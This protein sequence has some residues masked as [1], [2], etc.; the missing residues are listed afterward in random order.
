MV[1]ERCPFTNEP[2]KVLFLSHSKNPASKL[3]MRLHPPVRLLRVMWKASE[4]TWRKD[5]P[6]LLPLSPGDLALGLGHWGP[7]IEKDAGCV[8]RYRPQQHTTRSAVSSRS[9]RWSFWLLTVT[10]RWRLWFWA[11]SGITGTGALFQ[12]QAASKVSGRGLS[13]RDVPPEQPGSAERAGVQ[14]WRIEVFDIRLTFTTAGPGGGAEC[15]ERVETCSTAAIMAYSLHPSLL[16]SRFG[17]TG[18][19]ETGR[20]QLGRSK[21]SSLHGRG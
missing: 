15:R 16:P 21:Q 17:N 20:G 1:G 6:M 12:L 4:P 19:A 14:F 10:E 9:G 13:R 5:L 11:A 2:E 7:L 3:V 8:R 18:Q